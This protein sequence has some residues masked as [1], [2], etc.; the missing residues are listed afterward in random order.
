MD[1]KQM[2][3]DMLNQVKGSLDELECVCNDSFEHIPEAKRN[4]VESLITKIATDAKDAYSSFDD[5]ASEF[6]NS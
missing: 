5:L 6:E 2:I 3:A 4:E 1:W